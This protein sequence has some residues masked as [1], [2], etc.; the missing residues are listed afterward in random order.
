MHNRCKAGSGLHEPW[1]QTALDSRTVSEATIAMAPPFLLQPFV[2]L[3]YASRY[4][5]SGTMAM[6]S[7]V[8]LRHS[9]W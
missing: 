3:C 9:P 2:E 6:T 7:Q 5:L 8:S 4:G 1:D